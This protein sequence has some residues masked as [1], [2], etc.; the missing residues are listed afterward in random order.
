V[1]AI[2]MDNVT[3]NDKQTT[4]LAALNNSF[5]VFNRVR[6][7][8]HTFQLSAKTLLRPLNSGILG[9]S[10]ST[11]DNED[12]GD[13]ADE[14]PPLIIDDE[15]DDDNVDG[16]LNDDGNEMDDPD[17]EIDELSQLDSVVQQETIHKTVVVREAVSTVC[18]LL[19]QTYL[20]FPRFLP[21][22]PDFLERLSH[23]APIY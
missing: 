19:L 13:D 10:S 23:S 9:D 12:E 11:S 6:C 20:N 17:D 4:K 21:I 22:F 7:F 16:S 5:E 2:N 15:S 14:C 8:N 1:L 18:S 3:S